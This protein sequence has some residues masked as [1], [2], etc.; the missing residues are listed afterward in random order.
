MEET[1]IRV[2][3]Y[4]AN[5]GICSR[6]EVKQ[7]LKQQ[8]F[9]VN[10]EKIKEA[11]TRINPYTDTLMLNGKKLKPPQLVY[12]VIN[13]PKG[14]ISTTADEFGRKNVLSLIPTKE[15]IYSVGR[16]DKDTTGLLLLTNDGELTNQLI[17]P[18]Y[19]VD[20]TYTLSITGRVEKEQLQ[21]LRHGV[22]LEDGITYPAEV[23][24]IKENNRQSLLEMIIHEGRNRQIRRMCETVG[25]KLKELK[26]IKFGPLN[27]DVKE[28]RFRELTKK[29]I[30]LLKKMS[31]TEPSQQ[32]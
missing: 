18:K 31:H 26:R 12:Y 23:K 27:L 17:H 3:K 8:T 2:N 6:R 4:L 10:G 22:L 5:L 14:V 25:V 29:E 9:T 13:K 15:R 20:K 16:L 1:T 30:M 11:G 32:S 24:I 28:G 21:A 19:H 7:L